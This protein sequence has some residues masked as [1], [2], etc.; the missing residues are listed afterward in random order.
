MKVWRMCEG[1]SY[2]LTR[3]AQY[4]RARAISSCEG[5]AAFCRQGVV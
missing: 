1:A 4:A 2:V 5:R 3:F